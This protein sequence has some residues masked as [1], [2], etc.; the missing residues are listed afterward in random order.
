MAEASRPALSAPRRDRMDY[1]RVVISYS[2]N[3]APRV[4]CRMHSVLFFAV[5]NDRAVPPSLPPSVSM[6]S[7]GFVRRN[8][9]VDARETPLLDLSSSC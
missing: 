5:V 6:G 1:A 2:R 4:L 7:D 3:I 9:R 8:N